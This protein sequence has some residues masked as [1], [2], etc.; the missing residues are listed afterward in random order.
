MSAE[1]ERIVLKG[2]SPLSYEHPT[3]SA[4]LSS[5][6]K[7]PG[8]DRVLRFAFRLIH[9]RRAR[10][11]FLSCSVRVNERQFPRVNALFEEACQTLD[12]DRRPELF[13]TQTPI[14][15]AFAYG[16][17]KPFVV[18]HSSLID[19]L[20]DR[21][22]QSVL[23][24]ELGH[25]S[26]GHML[27]Y[28]VLTALMNV[29]KMGGLGIPFGNLGLRAFLLAL[30]E[31][32]RKAELTCD[33]AA[34]LV[35]Q[36]PLV[37]HHAQMKLAGGPRI[38]QMDLGSFMDQAIEY[39]DQNDV[40]DCIYKVLNN[41]GTTHPHPVARIR[42]LQRWIDQG[43]YQRILDGNYVTRDDSRHVSAAGQWKRAAKD[44]AYEAS[45]TTGDAVTS[46]VS[47][48][49]QF[50]DKF[51]RGGGG[52]FSQIIEAAEDKLDRKRDDFGDVSESPDI[53]FPDP[54]APPDYPWD[55][56]GKAARERARDLDREEPLPVLPPD[57]SEF[58]DELA[59]H[60][61]ESK[62]KP[63]NLPN[64]GPGG[65]GPK[66]PRRMGPQ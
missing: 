26:S 53:A 42:E 19:L 59:E 20:D 32:Y 56:G 41:W 12:L 55:D 6:G 35:V 65:D 44:V 57:F 11:E 62:P 43:D 40:L 39:E 4:A 51:K 48:A 60:A 46:L 27:Y 5:L 52:W 58:E 24:H 66:A 64:D 54:P 16:I 8:I 9:E 22:L 36:D 47:E 38:E 49:K 2:L 30:F 63:K 17:D 3:D 1:T 15:N 21:E 13:I 50:G 10:L 61:E 18:V 37:C 14:P 45:K 33:R 25:I 23:G 28:S 7:V 34:L 29:M 31:W